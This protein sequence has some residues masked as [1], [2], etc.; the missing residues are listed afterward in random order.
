[1]APRETPESHSRAYFAPPPTVTTD[2][3]SGLIS[4]RGISSLYN[5]NSVDGAN[6]WQNWAEPN[7]YDTRPTVFNSGLSQNGTGGTHERFFI[8]NWNSTVSSNKINEFRFQ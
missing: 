5:N 2:G 4:Y 8:V 3:S 6:N 7:G 1:M